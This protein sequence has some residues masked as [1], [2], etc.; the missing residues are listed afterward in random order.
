MLVAACVCT[1]QLLLAI[2]AGLQLMS[3]SDQPPPGGVRGPERAGVVQYP[4]C[5]RCGSRATS[6][7]ACS[8]IECLGRVKVTSKL[9]QLLEEDHVRLTNEEV[10]TRCRGLIT[11]AHSGFAVHSLEWWTL[12]RTEAFLYQPSIAGCDRVLSVICYRNQ[13]CLNH[14]GIGRIPLLRAKPCL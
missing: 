9:R 2:R 14:D 11:G 7:D 10:E 1:S 12:P 4:S 6:V 3:H 8:C 5:L 13:P